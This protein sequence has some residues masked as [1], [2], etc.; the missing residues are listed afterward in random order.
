MRSASNWSYGLK[1]GKPE[2]SIQKGY[3][4]LIERAKNF[5]YIENQFFI[6]DI[7]KNSKVKE[8]QNQVVQT[9]IWRIKRAIDFDEDLCTII[10]LPMLPGF[11][12]DIKETDGS[13][14]R[15]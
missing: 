15:K 12:G 1:L 3:L 9:L 8:V 10:V 11:P 14:L 4:R 5:I 2:K 13:L 7:S 6:S